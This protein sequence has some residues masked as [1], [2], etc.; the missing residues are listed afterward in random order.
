MLCFGILYYI[1]LYGEIPYK[2]NP[3]YGDIPY[4]GKSLVIPGL[5]PAGIPPPGE[6]VRSSE[7]V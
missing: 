2:E 7:H 4:K 5:A 1:P 6:P 3:L